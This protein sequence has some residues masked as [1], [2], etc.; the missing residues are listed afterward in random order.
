MP[1]GGGSSLAPPVTLR[2]GAAGTTALAVRPPSGASA[3]QTDEL[4][5]YNDANTLVWAIDAAGNMYGL[6]DS[7]AFAVWHAYS[8]AS[9]V[10][11]SVFAIGGDGA[12]YIGDFNTTNAYLVLHEPHVAPPDAVLGNGDVSLWLDQTP[13]ATKLMVKAKDSGGTVRTTTINLT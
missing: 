9:G 5:V 11:R 1:F 2:P 12:T 4:E 3:A 10:A 13:G 7:A 6:L 8:N